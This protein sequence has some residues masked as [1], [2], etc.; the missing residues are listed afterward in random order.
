MNQTRAYQSRSR[1][2][3]SMTQ[4]L[5]PLS[6][7]K[8]VARQAPV[9][10]QAPQPSPQQQSQNAQMSSSTTVPEDP[11]PQPQPQAPQVFIQQAPPPQ[12]QL[13]Q[14][15]APQVFVPQK[16]PTNPQ[17][18][19]GSPGEKP[20]VAV[21]QQPAPL[22]TEDDVLAESGGLQADPYN[23]ALPVSE[24]NNPYTPQSQANAATLS[25]WQRVIQ[26]PAEYPLFLKSIGVNV[27]PGAQYDLQRL[28]PEVLDMLTNLI[29]RAAAGIGG[30]F[31]DFRGFF[32]NQANNLLIQQQAPAAAPQPA[33]PPQGQR[34]WSEMF[35]QPAPV[36]PEPLQR[37]PVGRGV[38]GGRYS[39][40]PPGVSSGNG[41]YS[42]R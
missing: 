23:P 24:Q 34:G 8:P 38:P 22:P 13:P 40:S 5:S 17:W 28:Q 25:R 27:P 7:R 3:A 20:P 15:Q 33:P 36:E 39:M 11:K 4:Q 29:A 19:Q 26:N 9:Y 30:G 1:G 6:S 14:Q 35:S 32:Q 37:T 16:D 12:Q 41:I 21:P 2:S 10:P 18:P 31:E 42:G